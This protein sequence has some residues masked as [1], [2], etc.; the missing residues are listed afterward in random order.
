MTPCA[1]LICA[2]E[3][4]E[5]AAALLQHARLDAAAVVDREG[6]FVGLLTNEPRADSPATVPK[7]RSSTSVRLVRQVMTTGVPTFAETASLA[8]L[9]EFFTTGEQPLAVVV[10][11]GRPSGIVHCDGLA[12]L[13][14]HLTVD[15]F[16]PAMPAS[17][18]S[19][20]LRVPDLCLAET[21]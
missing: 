1:L 4:I 18:T 11:H 20:Y 19:N 21:S 7:P 17:A 5:S 14:D 2:D 13:N 6:L 16:L 9:M 8:E 15:N 3:T 10:R 12:A